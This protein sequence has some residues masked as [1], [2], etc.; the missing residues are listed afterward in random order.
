MAPLERR[1]SYTGIDR[2][3]NFE[4]RLSA[5][6]RNLIRYESVGCD[7]RNNSFRRAEDMAWSSKMPHI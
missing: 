3:G 5:D 4:R 6:R 7:R 1:K 2:R